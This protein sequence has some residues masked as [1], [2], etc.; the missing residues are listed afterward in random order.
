MELKTMDLNQIEP[1]FTEIVVEIDEQM[2][3][4]YFYISIFREPCNEEIGGYEYNTNSAIIGENGKKQ[5]RIL[6]AYTKYLKE[7]L[8]FCG[9]KDLRRETLLQ[10]Y[11]LFYAKID[12]EVNNE[13]YNLTR[14]KDKEVNINGINTYFSHGGGLHKLIK[15][16]CLLD[17]E[18]PRKIIKTKKFIEKGEKLLG[19]NNFIDNS[20][21]NEKHRRAELEGISYINICL[22]FEHSGKYKIRV[23]SSDLWREPR[24][25]LHFYV[26][27]TEENKTRCLAKKFVDYKNKEEIE[28]MSQ[29]RVGICLFVINYNHDYFDNYTN[30]VKIEVFNEADFDVQSSAN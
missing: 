14:F 10:I 27:I 11:P 22:K 7:G 8:L 5:M 4:K 25:E 21:I 15:I 13:L 18:G 17:L 28:F 19:Q 23:L 9:L 16:D 20:V 26:K 6:R 29:L 24:I 12:F 30:L 2:K 3:N 1:Y